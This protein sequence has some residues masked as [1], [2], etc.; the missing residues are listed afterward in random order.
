MK[1]HGTQRFV[2]TLTGD[3]HW[4]VSWVK[5]IW[6]IYF[7]SACLRFTLILSFWSGLGPSCG[8]SLQVFWSE[9]CIHLYTII[10]AVN[11]FSSFFKAHTYIV[12]ELLRGGELLDRIRKKG[13]YTESEAR[14]IMRKLI[15]ALNYMQSRGV[16]HRDLK[17]EV[18]EVSHHL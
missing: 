15:S 5:W 16:V 1:F 12:L 7:H 3:C 10:W 4:S 9:F 2:T 11:S 18:C 13:R 17:P 14:R 6:S 8:S